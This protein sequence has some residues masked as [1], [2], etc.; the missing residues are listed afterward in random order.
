M[1]HTDLPQVDSIELYNSTETSVDVSGWWLTDNNNQHAKFQIP[2]GSVIAAGSYL[3]FD[4][5]DFNPTPLTP[6]EHHFS[7]NSAKGD[8]IYLLKGSIGNTRPLAFCDH[9]EFGAAL[10]GVVFGRSPNGD[11]SAPFVPL[12]TNTLGEANSLPRF[13]P[14]I[15]TEILAQPRNTGS[16][17][18]T[19]D[20]EYIEIHNSSAN[21]VN[22]TNWRLRKGIDF[23]F[24]ANTV[25]PARGTLAIL[26]FNPDKPETVTR[27]L[28]SHCTTAFK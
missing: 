9:V 22:L 12:N 26:S 4:E 3:I 25:L 10:N 16:E 7:L 8:D 27:P 19:N 1:T 21:P 28:L 15:I 6:L 24:P 17:E 2:S 14:V 13:G 23:D 11:T 20:L 5:T 18:D